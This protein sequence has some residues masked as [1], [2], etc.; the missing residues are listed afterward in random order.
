[1][2]EVRANMKIV[3]PSCESEDN[4]VKGENVEAD[5]TSYCDYIVIPKTLVH[6]TY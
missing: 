6:P 3:D 2:E 1:M 5:K 4:S